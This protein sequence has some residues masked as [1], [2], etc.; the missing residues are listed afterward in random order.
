MKLNHVLIA[1][2]KI[3]IAGINTEQEL[4]FALMAVLTKAKTNQFYS[5]VQALF[6]D[7]SEGSTEL[8][9]QLKNITYRNPFG[10]IFRYIMGIL[11]RLRPFR[12]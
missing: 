12:N 4:E 7:Y 2:E 11:Q 9:E 5:I 6:V 3:A 8:Y 1:L 10:S